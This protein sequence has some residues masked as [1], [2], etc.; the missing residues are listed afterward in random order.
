MMKEK[1]GRIINTASA[2]GIYGNRGQANYSAAKLGLHGFTMSL[3]LEGAKNNI[4]C[5]TI[6]PV[7]AS[8]MTETVMPKELLAALKPEYVAPLVGYLT[9][10]SCKETGALFEIGGGWISRLR[11]ERSKGAIFRADASFLPGSVAAKWSQIN[12]F[13]NADHPSK[14]SDVDWLGALE[15]ARTGPSNPAGPDLR[16]ENRVAVVT[17]A[18]GGLGRAYAMLFAS[19]GAKVVVNDLGGSFKGDGSGSSNAADKVVDEIRAAGGVAVANY[20]SVTEGDKIIDTAIKAFGRVDVLVNNAGILRDKSFAK[21]SPD[22][23][24]WDLIQDV[25]VRTYIF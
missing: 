19:L 6:A 20:D 17:G 5:N 8:R 2:A 24:D 15:Q 9:H 23:K 25:H 10:D 22:G 21:M 1:Y 14:L 3:A 16:F 13:K 4:I 12:D 11:W 18:G 7:A